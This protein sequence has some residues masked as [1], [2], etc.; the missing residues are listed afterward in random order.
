MA[1]RVLLGLPAN[2]EQV[3]R[4]LGPK[5]LVR[6]ATTVLRRGAEI[7]AVLAVG[8]LTVMSLVVRRRS[9]DVVAA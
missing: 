7:C 1:D 6:K 3:A 5:D 9:R 2:R 4:G 8:A